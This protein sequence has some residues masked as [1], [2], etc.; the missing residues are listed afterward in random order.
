MTI[1]TVRELLQTSS[2]PYFRNEF[3]RLHLSQLIKQSFHAMDQSDL[4]N[5]GTRTEI[6]LEI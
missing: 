3:L 1:L 2:E 4:F 5:D 6:V